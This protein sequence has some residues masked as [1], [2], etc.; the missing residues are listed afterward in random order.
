[1]ALDSAYDQQWLQ[2]ALRKGSDGK[3]ALVTDDSINP[4]ERIQLTVAAEVAKASN[5]IQVRWPYPVLDEAQLEYATIETVNGA[6]LP[7]GTSVGSFTAVSGTLAG[8]DL[9]IELTLAGTDVSLDTIAEDELVQIE[10]I[11]DTQVGYGG[12][13]GGCRVGGRRGGRQA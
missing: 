11:N 1:M 10:Q 3:I 5:K 13:A 4:R 6:G 9:V 12:E 8:K 2:T 7:V